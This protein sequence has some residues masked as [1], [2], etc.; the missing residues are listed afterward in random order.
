MGR[1]RS[2]RLFGD[3]EPPPKRERQSEAINAVFE[4]WRARQRLPAACKLTA[5][6]RKLIE[7]AVKDHG[8]DDLLALVRYAYDADEP[9]PRFWRGDNRQERTYLDL[10]N[11]L[12][13][14]KLAGRV[15]AALAW[16]MDGG[17]EAD[18]TDPT[19]ML[20]QLARRAPGEPARDVGTG[21]GAE[22]RAGDRTPKRRAVRATTRRARA[23]RMARWE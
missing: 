15:E 22:G 8:T 9:G 18:P 23:C 7:A 6:R 3:A 16:V 11:L 10:T 1:V 5:P 17:A 20:A 2:G 4:A 13:R 14:S 21:P 19:A 12:V